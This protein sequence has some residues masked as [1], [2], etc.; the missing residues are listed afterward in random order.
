MNWCE[1]CEEDDETVEAGI[2]A[3]CA[4]QQRANRE[5]FARDCE[6]NVERLSYLLSN[7]D[8]DDRLYHSLLHEATNYDELDRH[9]G[10]EYGPPI[11]LECEADTILLNRVHAA[12]KE[13]YPEVA[14]I[15]DL[16]PHAFWIE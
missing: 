10:V 8:D 13:T 14:G 12:L 15:F 1:W 7:K 9:L 5:E 2:C 4:A 6:I 11:D 16:Y 3:S